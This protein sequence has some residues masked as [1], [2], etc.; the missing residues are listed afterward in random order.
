MTIKDYLAGLP[1]MTTRDGGSLRE[2]MIDSVSIWSNEAALGYAALALD[3]AGVGHGTAR[4]VLRK[5]R[6]AFDD[7]SIAQAEI[8]GGNL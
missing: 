1:D 3:R 2:V 5:M 6:M 7:V 4:E 8:I